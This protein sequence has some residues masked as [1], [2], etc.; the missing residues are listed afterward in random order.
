MSPCFLSNLPQPRPAPLSA[1]VWM[2][3]CYC[4]PRTRQTLRASCVIIST[5]C[6]HTYIVIHRMTRNR[7]TASHMHIFHTILRRILGASQRRKLLLLCLGF[8]RLDTPL[9]QQR[10]SLKS[11]YG[12][13]PCRMQRRTHSGA[14]QCKRSSFAGACS[15]LTLAASSPSRLTG[16]RRPR[17]RPSWCERPAALVAPVARAWAGSTLSSC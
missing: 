9:C 17:A 12:I 2:C 16:R 8:Q 15:S 1:C 7:F 10:W 4:K 5:W 14:C 6:R 13:V 3:V 11:S